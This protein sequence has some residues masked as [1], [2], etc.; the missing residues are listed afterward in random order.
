M[1]KLHEA[2]GCKVVVLGLIEKKHTFLICGLWIRLS[3]KKYAACTWRRMHSYDMR[4]LDAT[5]CLLRCALS[6]LRKCSQRPK[7]FFEVC[8]NNQCTTANTYHSCREKLSVH[9]TY[10]RD[11]SLH[12]WI[13]SGRSS[14]SWIMEKGVI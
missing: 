8:I 14:G 10:A 1:N 4:L 2:V 11:V 13:A 6:V 7:A 9:N 5:T 12:G 3:M